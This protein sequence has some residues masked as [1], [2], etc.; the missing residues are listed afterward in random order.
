[1]FSA[2]VLLAGPEQVRLQWHP[3]WDV[4]PTPK[5][6]VVHDD[7]P[8]S[9][10]WMLE[11]SCIK[12]EKHGECIGICVH[13]W[14]HCPLTTPAIVQH[15]L[16]RK[17]AAA[18]DG[19]GV[20]PP[21]VKGWRLRCWNLNHLG[22]PS[23]DD[24]CD[25]EGKSVGCRE[26]IASGLSMSPEQSCVKTS[27]THTTDEKEKREWHL[28]SPPCSLWGILKSSTLHHA[29]P[30]SSPHKPPSLFGCWKMFVTPQMGKSSETDA[31]RLCLVY[32]AKCIFTPLATKIWYQNESLTKKLTSL[33]FQYN[34]L[35][36]TYA[37][38]MKLAMYPSVEDLC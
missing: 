24:S 34:H 20:V 1:M 16:G 5:S 15:L 38:T 19:C 33:F 18:R 25:G 2:V 36:L 12:W 22:L 17:G 14:G 29:M 37:V 35:Q 10:K 6:M 28:S 3:P 7:L 21:F 26:G 30:L 23:I 27:H 4:S 31:G 13:L 9:Q 32:A 11:R 8:T